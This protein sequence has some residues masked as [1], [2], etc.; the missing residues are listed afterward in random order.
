MKKAKEKIKEMT[1]V[2]D[3]EV[4]DIDGTQPTFDKSNAQISQTEELV[5]EKIENINSKRY[6]IDK[7]LSKP[8]IKS[9]GILS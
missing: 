1:E 2:K 3:G 6:R 4:V 5:E 8:D 7:L 9:R